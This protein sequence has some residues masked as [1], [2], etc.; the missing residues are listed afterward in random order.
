[1]RTNEGTLVTLNTLLGIPYRNEGSYTALLISRCTL[2]P[3][4]I[5]VA[6]EGRYGKKVT[7]LCIDG[8]YYLV[9]ECRIIV[10]HLL[11][12]GKVAPSS[13]YYE[14]LVLTT[15]IYSSVVL[16]YDILT[17]LAV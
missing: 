10:G 4:T 3:C 2:R 8:A 6:L 14:F 5:L 12:S 17:L 9:D 11:I 15:A 1:V 7:V 16:V 13:I